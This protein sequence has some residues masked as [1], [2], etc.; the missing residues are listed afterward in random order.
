LNAYGCP[1]DKKLEVLLECDPYI[2]A[3]TAFSPNGN[4]QNDEF[5][6]YSGFL[7]DE[8]FQISI[9]NRWGEIVFHSTDKNFRWNGGYD[10]GELMPGGTYVYVIKYMSKYQQ[11]KGVQEKRG[12]VVLLR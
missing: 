11:Q 3:P 7:M 8:N 4:G 12:G 1:A 6:I 5:F 10:N 2:S 9:F